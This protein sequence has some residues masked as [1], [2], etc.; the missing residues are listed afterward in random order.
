MGAR[1]LP[2]D[3]ARAGGLRLMG[4]HGCGGQG[5]RAFERERPTLPDGGGKDWFAEGGTQR[6]ERGDVRRL[7]RGRE[8]SVDRLAEGS[9]GAAQ[10]GAAL[11][12]AAGEGQACGEFEGIGDAA[13]VA[14]VARQGEA[15]G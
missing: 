12:L 6:R 8:G 2:S 9:G 7:V 15:F 13:A 1:L 10:P 14:D 3:N 4:I 5:D 11:R